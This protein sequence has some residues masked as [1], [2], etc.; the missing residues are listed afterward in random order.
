MKKTGRL[1]AFALALAGVAGCGARQTPLSELSAD[2]LW[3]RGVEEFNDEDWS[4]AI[5]YFDRYILVGGS[6][7]RVH[8]ARY[9]VGQARF[10]NGEYVTAAAEFA[11]LAGDLGRLDLA[12]DA[13]F[14]ACRAYDELSPGPQ[15][16]QEYT[17]AAIDHCQAL[18]EYF[19][20]SEFAGDAREIVDDMWNKLA[21][22]LYEGGDWYFRRRAYDSAIIYY[23]DV[24]ERYP[25]TEYAPKALGRLVE[26]YTILEYDEELEAVKERL[27]RE[28]PGAG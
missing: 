21:E 12:D 8:Q 27:Q 28:Y 23:E 11:R 13:R 17:R 18:I 4:G 6:D 19:P 7:P 5:R 16:D 22:K 1:A 15:L 9:Y 2:E 14:M 26:I 24:V 3:V 25:Q 20:D 10:E